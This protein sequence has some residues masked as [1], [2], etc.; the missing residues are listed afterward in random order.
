MQ[1]AQ[2]RPGLLRHLSF[3]LP[4]SLSLSV[5]RSA[6][7]SL[8]FALLAFVVAALEPAARAAYADYAAHG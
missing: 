3:C 2:V 6:H 4:A 7:S 1:I 5:C 8:L